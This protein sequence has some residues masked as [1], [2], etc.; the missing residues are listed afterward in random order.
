M[1]EE[2]RK[3]SGEAVAP[4]PADRDDVEDFYDRW[5]PEYEGQ[6]RRGRLGVYT[7]IVLATLR[8]L[9]AGGP[10]DVLD[11]G[12]GTGLIARQLAAEGHRVTMVDV[13]ATMLSEARVGMHNG[14][15]RLARSDLL[16]LP[17]AS[18]RTFDLVYSEGS[19][20]SW[21]KD[22]QGALREFARVLR[23]GGQLLF[24][25]QN[26][27]FMTASG[28]DV[29]T[30]RRIYESGIVP[31]HVLG[32]EV[33][34]DQPDTYA[35]QR[36]ELRAAVEATGLVV[37]RIGSRPVVTWDL[38][39]DGDVDGDDDLRADLLD[40]ELRLQWDEDAAALG[41]QLVVHARKPG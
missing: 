33:E 11:A 26:R 16:D 35:F 12:G 30:A 14:A 32:F 8:E 24:S 22:W 15:V 39:D 19:T 41:R 21:V 40:L 4:G 5:A 23:P 13:S 17:M 36:S 28:S 37:E 31:S 25:G 9:L 38:V 20:L 7:D 6:F 2:T 27:V 29:A 1:A 3:P 34:G 18:G 10:S